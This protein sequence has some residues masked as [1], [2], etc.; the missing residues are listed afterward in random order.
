MSELT[1]TIDWLGAGTQGRFP[2]VE[3][4]AGLVTSPLDPPDRPHD[5]DRSTVAIRLSW[6]AVSICFFRPVESTIG[7]NGAND[8]APSR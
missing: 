4:T 2:G 8:A 6:L 5:L 3:E 7:L 1:L